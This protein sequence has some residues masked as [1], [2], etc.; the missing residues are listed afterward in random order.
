MINWI[1]ERPELRPADEA[2]VAAEF[3][4]LWAE[5]GPTEHGYATRYHA[6]AHRMAKQLLAFK[7]DTGVSAGQEIL[8]P[9]PSSASS[10][11][12]RSHDV[13]QTGSNPSV[14]R[15]VLTKRISKE[16]ADALDATMY[17]LAGRQQYGARYAVEVVSL[18]TAERR[19]LETTE[20]KL[21]G[22]ILKCD[23]MLAAMRNGKFPAEPDAMS[24][25]RC[26]H[27]FACDAAPGGEIAPEKV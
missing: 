18:T 21:N 5:R 10:V 6:L 11:L 15:Y 17:H 13:T 16:E 19:V 2:V 3:E 8:V 26:P 7:A 27:F 4:R 24:C 22:R 23:D 14:I 9:F 12:I 20:E 1:S 25:P